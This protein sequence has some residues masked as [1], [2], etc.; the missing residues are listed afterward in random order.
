MAAQISGLKEERL[1]LSYSRDDMDAALRILGDLSDQ[2]KKL[3]RGA[4]RRRSRVQDQYRAILVRYVKRKTGKL[5]DRLVCDL[6]E[7]ALAPPPDIYQIG[8]DEAE[9]D[10]DHT[11]AEMTVEAHTRWRGRNKKLIDEPPK[12]EEQWTQDLKRKAEQRRRRAEPKPQK[13]WPLDLGLKRRKN[14]R[15]RTR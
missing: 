6:L 1:L 2:L 3:Q 11:W 5:H 13:L 4:D 8:V 12:L 9:V 15:D 7:V 14:T 10:P